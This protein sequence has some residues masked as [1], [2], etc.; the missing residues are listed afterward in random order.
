M[1]VFDP[2]PTQSAELSEQHPST[3]AAI[4]SFIIISAVGLSIVVGFVSFGAWYR[5]KRRREQL[6]A[7]IEL[8]ELSRIETA[9]QTSPVQQQQEF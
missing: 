6:E 8:V 9:L 7:A 4:I 3:T 2:Q 1:S 5:M